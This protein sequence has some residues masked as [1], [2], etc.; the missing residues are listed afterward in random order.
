[1]GH[2]GD[3]M[4]VARL[5]GYEFAMLVPSESASDPARDLIR[6]VEAAE[7]SFGG[8]DYR[9]SASAGV[10]PTLPALVSAERW[11]RASEEAL[12][13]SRQQ[14]HGKVS[15]YALDAGDQ[16]RQEQIAAKVASLSDLNEE[17]MLLRCQKIIPLHAKASMAA[18]YEVL[19]S[20]YDDEG[21][22]ITGRDFVRM[23]ERYDRMQAV[24]R[25]VVGHMLDWLREQA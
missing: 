11:L 3:G 19:I 17:R 22:L 16:A 4:P 5:A 6:A 13:A 21:N 24:D 8:R 12:A 23:A 25:W 20:M 2:V 9:L 10:V 18:Q 7:F 14:G 1:M 15:E